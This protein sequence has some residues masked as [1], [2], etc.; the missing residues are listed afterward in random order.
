VGF[1]LKGGWTY[2]QNAGHELIILTRHG[3]KRKEYVLEKPTQYFCEE[4]N[5]EGEVIRPAYSRPWQ[6]GDP[7]GVVQ[8]YLVYPGGNQLV[9]LTRAALYAV[10]VPKKA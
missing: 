4:R 10:D 7:A 3:V 5:R 9:L 8:Q 1:D 2:T 6:E